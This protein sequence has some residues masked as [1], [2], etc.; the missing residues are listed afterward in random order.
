M[1][2]TACGVISVLLSSTVSAKN[3]ARLN[4]TRPVFAECRLEHDSIHNAPGTDRQPTE[5][6]FR[7]KQTLGGPLLIHGY[8]KYL[9]KAEEAFALKV[10]E[11]ASDQF[12]DC[13]SA[14]AADKINTAS[15]L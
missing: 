3:A 14:G 13:S 8:S 5:G 15:D 6:Y 4:T 10:H 9:P 1:F 7:L 11:M 12:H 2:A